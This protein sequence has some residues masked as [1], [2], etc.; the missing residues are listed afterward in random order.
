MEVRNLI[1]VAVIFSGVII[2]LSGFYTDLADS[3]GRGV[4]DLASF[5]RTREAQNEI[6]QL[7]ESIEGETVETGTFVDI[8]ATGVFTT[9]KLVMSVPDIFSTIIADISQIV[10]LPSW[11]TTMLLSLITIVVVFQIIKAVTK[12]EL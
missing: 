10:G 8:L 12:T 5:N 7:K 4:T 9:L 2:G 6:T 1:I 11:F 3:Y